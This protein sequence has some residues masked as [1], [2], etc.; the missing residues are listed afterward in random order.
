MIIGDGYI[1]YHF[2]VRVEAGSKR[3]F[4][5]TVERAAE[6]KHELERV[7]EALGPFPEGIVDRLNRIPGIV[8]VCP[9][10]AISSV[11]NALKMV[12]A[13]GGRPCTMYGI[14]G[15]GPIARGIQEDLACA[16]VGLRATVRPGADSSIEISFDDTGFRFFREFQI[17]FLPMRDRSHLFRLEDGQEE[18]MEGFVLSR[19]NRGRA[20]AAR[21]LFRRGRLVSLCVG[22]FSQHLHPDDYLG[23]LT[24]AQQVLINHPEI[25]QMARALGIALPLDAQPDP[26]AGPLLR[27]AESL[28]RYGGGRRLVALVFRRSVLLSTP[29]LGLAAFHVPGTEKHRVPVS[30]FH[31]ALIARSFSFENGLPGYASELES[32]GNTAL[33]AALHG[34]DQFPL[35]YPSPGFDCAGTRPV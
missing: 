1:P 13:F 2:R 21:R 30:R 23:L 20:A 12:R 15:T 29:D 18:A 22:G 26:A 11:L 24:S 17:H 5:Q 10:G 31:G 25:R 34:C 9:D 32:L 35:G 33:Q 28:G 16:D 19:A 7:P 6:I 14:V 8:Q 27:L 3:E 4:E